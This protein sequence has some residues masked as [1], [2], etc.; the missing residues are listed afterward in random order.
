MLPPNR[1]AQNGRNTIE[2]NDFVFIYLYILVCNQ[3]IE[4][5]REGCV[6]LDSDRTQ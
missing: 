4:N 6:S 1:C 3:F 2:R 5:D